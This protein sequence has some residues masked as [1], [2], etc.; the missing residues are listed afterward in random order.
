YLC[1]D[2]RWLRLHTNF[3]HHRA[4]VLALL[5]AG[6][7][8]AARE[9]AAPRTS[10]MTIGAASAAQWTRDAVA[11]ALRREWTAAEFEEAATRH[12]LVVAMMRSER[13]FWEE[14][15]QGQAVRAL[16]EQNGKCPITIERIDD[17]SPAV[18]FPAY[19]KGAKTGAMPLE[20]IRVMD[21]TRII[22]A[23]VGTRTLATYGA[24]VLRLSSPNL[25]DID[26]LVKDGSRGKRSAFVDLETPTGREDFTRLLR[27]TDVFVQSYRPGALDRFGFDQASCVAL[28]PGLVHATLCAYSHVGPWAQKRGFDS[29]VQCATGFNLD[30]A[31]EYA[32]YEHAVKGGDPAAF[33][34]DDS[35]LAP[36]AFPVQAL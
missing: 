32:R 22:A 21:L 7:E 23:P 4:G 18:A 17:G 3:A 26:V 8:A 9:L 1:K 25:P 10:P 28:R 19:D 14:H 33:N 13:E 20:G 15:P 24:D 35:Q 31:R 36:R 16:F 5:E 29:L 27:G 2:G 11:A 34:V 6:P 30:E 12:G